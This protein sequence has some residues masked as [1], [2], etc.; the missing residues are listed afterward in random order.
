MNKNENEDY[1]DTNIKTISSN[2]EIKS[3][4]EGLKNPFLKSL[5]FNKENDNLK[6]SIAPEIKKIQTSNL[7]NL[8]KESIL[9]SKKKNSKRDSL[10][11]RSFNLEINNIVKLKEISNENEI[12]FG[13][14]INEKLNS[15][16]NNFNSYL[17]DIQIKIEEKYTNYIL[18]INEYIEKNEKKI[19]KIAKGKSIEQA[20]IHYADRNIFKQINLIFEILN[21]IFESIKDNL[22]LLIKFLEDTSLVFEKNPLEK[23]IN[24]NSK[25]ILDSF[26]LSK[27]DFQKLNLSNLIDNENLSEI[28]KNYISKK[29]FNTCSYLEIQNQNIEKFKI[30]SEFLRDNFKNLH[31]L[32]LNKINNKSSIYSFLQQKIQNNIETLSI[33]KCK[34]LPLKYLPYCT[35]M[36]KFIIKNTQINKILIGENINFKHLQH[37]QFKNCKLNDLLLKDFLNLLIKNPTIQENLEIL[38]LSNNLFTLINLIE[39]FGKKGNLPKLKYFDLSGNNIYNFLYDNFIILPSIKILDLTNNN[40]ITSILFENIVKENQVQ[41]F[42]VLLSLNLFISNNEINCKNYKNYLLKNIQNCEYQIT[43]LVFS[44]MFNKN[45]CNVIQDIKLSPSIKLSLKYL[46]LSYCGLSSN[47]VINFL[48]GNFGLLNLKKLNLSY[49]FLTNE[50]FTLYKEKNNENNNEIKDEKCIF[51]K[52]ITLDLGFNEKISINLIDDL[53]IF[54][55]FISEIPSLQK[56]KLQGTKFENDYF[57][58]FSENQNIINELE[59]KL[60][61]KKFKIY[62]TF[63]FIDNKI[64][65]SCKIISFKNR[66][67]I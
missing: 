59:S 33:N 58:K 50:I 66:K 9:I 12:Q 14:F 8:F 48:K 52:L 25:L 24:N 19:S 7:N 17:N 21:N 13:N 63:K 42:L 36:F 22:N 47:I 61:N 1:R 43:N 44:L 55:N 35:N 29:Q 37:I 40:I 28:C 2:D 3:Y 62:F 39:F 31:K 67:E 10:F 18:F 6:F 41:K 4:S 51:E 27:I 32:K 65:N 57:N 16:K 45:N 64:L 15:L 60:P 20:F 23:Y 56:V 53:K 30:E 49:N 38:D 5:S 26:I 34:E 46:N 54:Y 11:R